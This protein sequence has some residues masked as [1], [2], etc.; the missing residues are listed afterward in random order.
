MLKKFGPAALSAVA[1]VVGWTG[2]Y[3][4][5]QA[6]WLGV[7]LPLATTALTWFAVRRGEALG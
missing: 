7:A 4:A 6:H 3:F 5:F 1:V 2:V